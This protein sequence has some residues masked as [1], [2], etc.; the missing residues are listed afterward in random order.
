MLWETPLTRLLGNTV[1]G[2]L[3][4]RIVPLRA[5]S[6]NAISLDEWPITGTGPSNDN[7]TITSSLELRSVQIRRRATI[8]MIAK[9]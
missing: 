8:V 2:E 9:E 1:P 5:D 6:T 7:G 3:T 4:L